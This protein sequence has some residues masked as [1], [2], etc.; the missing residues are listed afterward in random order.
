MMKRRRRRR[1]MRKMKTIR[2]LGKPWRNEYVV[3]A[4]IGLRLLDMYPYDKIIQ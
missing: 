4:L 3:V 1:K 2:E